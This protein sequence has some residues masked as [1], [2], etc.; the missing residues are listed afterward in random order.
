MKLRTLATSVGLHLLFLPA[1]NAQY[2][3]EGLNLYLQRSQQECFRYQRQDS[4]GVIGLPFPYYSPSPGPKAMFS[5]L[6]Y[7]DCFFT[8]RYGLL[9]SGLEQDKQMALN[10]VN[11]LLYLVDRFGFVPNANRFSMLNRSQ[12]PFLSLMVKDVFQV[13]GDAG[14][15][16]DAT[17]TLEKEYDFWM[18]NRSVDV[19]IGKKSYQLNRYGHQATDTYLN[20]FYKVTIKRLQFF[21]T[22]DAGGNTFWGAASRLDTILRAAQWL[23]EAESGWDF[24]PRFKGRCMEFLPVDLNAILGNYELNLAWFYDRLG[25]LADQLEQKKMFRSRANNYRRAF[26]QRLE[27]MNALMWDEEMGVYVDFNWVENK[28]SSILTAASFF[29]FWLLDTEFKRDPFKTMD[30]KFHQRFNKH[31]VLTLWKLLEGDI[32]M[33]VVAGYGMDHKTQWNFGNLWPPFQIIASEVIRY[34]LPPEYLYQS[35]HTKQAFC[36]AT[37]MY[38]QEKGMVVEKYLC[39]SD[40]VLEEYPTQ[41]M[42]GW[43]AAA[44][45]WFKWYSH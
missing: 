44:Y 2:S 29:P 30:V 20:H 8:N 37:E 13:T 16:E 12:P 21:D 34:T 25:E 33:P 18:K 36:N 7:W 6:Y 35:T 24:T 17:K 3:A 19:K 26:A 10:Q 27:A 41:P 23:A 22:L 5:E 32:V 15:L 11:N 9:P 4:G 43:T 45:R 14:W 1:T 42:M 28:K 40:L 39:K 38:F 31:T